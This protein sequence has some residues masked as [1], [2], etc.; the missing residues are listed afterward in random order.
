MSSFKTKY[1]LQNSFFDY[2]QDW[3]S[4]FFYTNPKL[5]ASHRIYMYEFIRTK[6]LLFLI[7]AKTLMIQVVHFSV[8]LLQNQEVT[9]KK[10]RMDAM[11]WFI[12]K[13]DIIVY[14]LIDGVLIVRIILQFR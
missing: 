7:S 13:A 9:H 11:C 8:D 12:T 6:D 5:I 10:K 14:G 2:N 4:F 1:D 3:N